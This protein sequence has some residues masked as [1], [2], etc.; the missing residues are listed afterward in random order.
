VARQA[1]AQIPRRLR[2]RVLIRSDSGGGTHEFLAWLTRPGRRL[3]YSV[4]FIITDDIAAAILAIPARLDAGGQVRDGA[5]LTGL[6]T[7]TSWPKGMRVIVRKERP[8][9]GAQL[10]FT[11]IDGHR[12]TCFATSARTGQLADLELRHRRRAR[13]E[14]R[15]RCAKDT[16]MRNLPL[17]GF[18]QNQIWCEIV[19]LACELLAGCRCSPLTGPPADGN[20]N[21]SACVCSPP[22]GA[23]SAAASACGCASP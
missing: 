7:S 15:I 3:A 21:A 22:P 14:D 20:Q 19:A 2:R 11:E 13:C 23:S 17:Q 8:H 9:P 6:L 10:R 1:L 4:G 16:G 12:F 18:D 5:E